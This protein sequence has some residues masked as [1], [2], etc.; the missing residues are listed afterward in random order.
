MSSPGYTIHSVGRSIP[1][2]KKSRY[3]KIPVSIEI[4]NPRYC[5]TTF[6]A[7]TT[8]IAKGTKDA[9]DW[10]Q[11]HLIGVPNVNLTAWG[12]KGGEYE[13][14]VSYERAVGD[15]LMQDLVKREKPTDES[16]AGV[17]LQKALRF[18]V[19]GEDFYSSFSE[20]LRGPIPAHKVPEEQTKL[21]FS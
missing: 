18:L 7:K 16:Y 19:N 8:V 9:L 10:V 1:H 6:K 2:G 14:F 3:K 11:A 13:R 4:T 20:R 15:A 12:P 5:I 21:E 17:D